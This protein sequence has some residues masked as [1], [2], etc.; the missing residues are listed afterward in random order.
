MFG[1]C[2]LYMFKNFGI[3]NPVLAMICSACTKPLKVKL[4]ERLIFAS[5]IFQY[6]SSLRI[7]LFYL[8]KL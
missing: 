3:L 8:F 2:V 5:F 6:W 4:P 1:H 7:I